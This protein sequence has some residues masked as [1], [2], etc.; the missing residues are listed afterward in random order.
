MPNP[1]KV[2]VGAGDD[3]HDAF[4][5]NQNMNNRQTW[6]EK[7]ILSR[8]GWIHVNTAEHIR[9]G[10]ICMTYLLLPVSNSVPDFEQIFGMGN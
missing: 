6:N 5:L 2:P 10:Y 7:Q 8:H 9:G 4:Q 3:L 1:L